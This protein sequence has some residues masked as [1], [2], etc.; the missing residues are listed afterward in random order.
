[1]IIITTFLKVEI[2]FATSLGIKKGVVSILYYQLRVVVVMT[3]FFVQEIIDIKWNIRVQEEVVLQ[4][5]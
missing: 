4:V 1:M 2:I 3:I 5:V